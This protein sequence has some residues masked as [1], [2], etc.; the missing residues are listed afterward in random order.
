MTLIG[1]VYWSYTEHAV[2]KIYIEYWHRLARSSVTLV[3]RE[4]IGPSRTHL[5]ILA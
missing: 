5:E 2:S 3:H 1:V 4:E